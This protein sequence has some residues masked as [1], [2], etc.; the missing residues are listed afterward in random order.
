MFF[1]LAF[2]IPL[3]GPTYTRISRSGRWDSQHIP[4]D[5]HKM[6]CAI[7][8]NNTAITSTWPNWQQMIPGIG[9]AVGLV[10]NYRLLNQL[11]KLP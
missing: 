10:V 8:S 4:D 11:S 6:D 7:S 3:T 2:P 1:Q 9:A 5:I